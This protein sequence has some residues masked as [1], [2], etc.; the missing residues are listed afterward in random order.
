MENW[1]DDAYDSK[2]TEVDK[3]RTQVRE[4]GDNEVRPRRNEM[5]PNNSRQDPGPVDNRRD[6]KVWLVQFRKK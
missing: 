5:S 6:R 2:R 1:D 4:H 3:R